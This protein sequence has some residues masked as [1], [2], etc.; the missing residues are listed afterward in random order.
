MKLAW[1][2]VRILEDYKKKQSEQKLFSK[3]ILWF[4]YGF[5]M[6]SD[7]F[8][9]SYIVIRIK[10]KLNTKQETETGS[11]KGKRLQELQFLYGYTTVVT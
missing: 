2:L 1:K 4:I 9:L 7:P 3:T 11:Q 8:L 6:R 10:K 5:N